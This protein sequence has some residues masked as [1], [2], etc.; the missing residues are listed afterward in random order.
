MDERAE[1]AAVVHKYGEWVVKVLEM[2]E[3]LEVVNINTIRYSHYF[4][5]VRVRP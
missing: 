3:L 1:A 4:M 5:N 2:C